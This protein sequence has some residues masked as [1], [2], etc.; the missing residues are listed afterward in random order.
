MTRLKV[1]V[2][3]DLFPTPTRPADGIFVERQAYHLKPWCDQV[4]VVSVRIF[5]PLR[6][7]KYLPRPVRLLA[8]WKDWKNNIRQIPIAGEVNGLP[9]FYVRYTSLP[10]P[11]FQSS[12]GFCAYPFLKRTLE[13]LHKR[14]HFDLIHAHWTV[15]SGVIA[16]LAQRWMK[17]PIVVSIHGSEVTYVARKTV[18]GPAVVRWALRKASIVVANSTW[19][20]R[21]ILK[22]GVDREK[23]TIIRLGGNAPKTLQFNPDLHRSEVVQLL[24]VGVLIKRKGHYFVVEALRVLLDM[25]YLFEYTVVGDGPEA[26]T[27]TRKVEELGLNNVVHFMG[28]KSPVDVWPYFS[29]CDIFVLPSWAEAFGVVYVEALGLGKPVIGCRGEGGPEELKALGD[30]VELVKPHDVSTL[31]DAIRRLIDDPARRERMGNIGKEIVRQYYTWE[32]NAAATIEIYR[33]VIDRT[34]E[35]A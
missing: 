13:A 3:S 14:Y 15:P 18:M 29:K 33:K 9:T 24:S 23:L 28:H 1:L 30:C 32:Q 8:E 20:A 10:K 5:P 4:V 2:L 34:K 12:W 25:G 31:V 27:L 26:S 6:I 19:T 11:L 35:D 22:Y 16:V 21:E 17:V 7:W